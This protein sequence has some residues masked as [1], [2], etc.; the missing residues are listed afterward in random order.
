M[1][2]P[3]SRAE[4]SMFHL[5]KQIGIVSKE[6]VSLQK[7]VHVL[8]LKQSKG[9]APSQTTATRACFSFSFSIL[10]W[11]CKISP[12]FKAQYNISSCWLSKKHLCQKGT[13]LCRV[14]NKCSQHCESSYLEDSCRLDYSNQWPGCKKTVAQLENYYFPHRAVLKLLLHLHIGQVIIQILLPIK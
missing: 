10:S 13:L 1:Q 9:S 5:L 11:P 7:R 14:N 12:Y 8:S 3:V 4:S 2:L 6:Q